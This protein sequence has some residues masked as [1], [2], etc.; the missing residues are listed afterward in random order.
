MDLGRLLLGVGGV[1][2]LLG[3]Q[4][5]VDGSGSHTSPV[6]VETAFLASNE[7]YRIGRE[8][9][10]A[11]NFG[12][13]ERRFREAVEQNADDG[14]SWL[15][16]AAAYDN[17]RRF[18]LADRAYERAAA[19]LGETLALLNNR[20]YSFHLRG[21]RPRALEQIRRARRL[22]PDSPVLRNN[23]GLVVSGDRPTRAGAP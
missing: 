1:C 22:F 7:L 18:E 6:A 9:L 10:E 20:A 13:A 16:L 14:A 2:A 5:A 17:L 12:L 19:L 3:C 8:D 15:G 11:G 4:T 23:L 21:D